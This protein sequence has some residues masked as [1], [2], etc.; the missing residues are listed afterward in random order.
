MSWYCFRS[1]LISGT[2]VP[3]PAAMRR[4]REAS[5]TLGLRRSALVIEPMI[6]SCRFSTFSSSFASSICFLILA[7]PGSMPSTPPM[8][9]IFLSW[10]SWPARSSRSK[11][12][13]CSFFGELFGLFLVDRLGGLLDQ[14]DDVAHAEDAAGDALGV[15]RL[16]RVDLLAGAHELDRLAGDG[17]HRERGAAARIA[18]DAGQHDAGDADAL[19]KGLADIDRVLAGHGVDDEQA[20]GRLRGVAHRRHLVHQ[21]LVDVE[22]AGGVEDEDVV[23]FALGLLERAPGDVDRPLA[24]RRSAA[25]AR[26][27]GGRARRAAPAPPDAARRARPSAPSCAR[28]SLRRRASLAEVVVLPEPCSPTIMMT[29]GGTALRLK[30]SSARAAQGLD[31]MVVDDL[32]DHL[33]RRDRAQHLLP[34]RLLAHAVDEALDHRQRHV[35][36]EQ[37]DA[38]LAQRRRHVVFAERAMARQPVEHGGETVAQALE[39]RHLQKPNGPVRDTRGLAGLRGGLL[40]PGKRPETRAEG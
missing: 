7:M 25:S 3:E 11:L 39:H 32:H 16:E 27:S 33:R 5:S 1:R 38:D 17:A 29:T 19:G 12:P 20:L 15:E 13:F 37:R 18:V 40:H 24:Q 14:A 8:P 10:R 9:P 22:P 28:A 23:A 26:R 6:A 2:E 31:Q 21:R 34:D 4:R 35:G 36:L 30:P